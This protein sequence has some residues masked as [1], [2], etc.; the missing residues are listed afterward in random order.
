[1]SRRENTGLLRGPDLS[2]ISSGKRRASSAAAARATSGLRKPAV[3]NEAAVQQYAALPWRITRKGA[4]QVL[5]VTSRTSGRWIL[6]KGWLVKGRSPAQSAEREAFEEAGVVGQ[7]GSEP[8]GSYYH[9]KLHDD[10]SVEIRTVT[11]FDQRVTG[12]LLNW[13][14]KGERKRLWLS[15]DEAVERA[16][17]PG[18]A[19]LLRSLRPDLRSETLKSRLSGIYSMA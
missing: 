3:T 10:G 13:P 7:V 15:R 8:I 6:P 4:F 11:V 1:M 19:D 9:S 2:G 5:L 12:T 16:G 14:E 17:E 18:L